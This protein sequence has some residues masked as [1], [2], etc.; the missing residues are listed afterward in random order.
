MTPARPRRRTLFGTSALAVAAL[1]LSACGLVGSPPGGGPAPTAAPTS[2]ASQSAGPTPTAS[3]TR[4]ATPAPTA[5]TT[6]TSTPTATASPP[7]TPAPTAS[8]PPGGSTDAARAWSGTGYADREEW[9]D[10][11][12]FPV[13]IAETWND[14][15]DEN[16]RTTWAKMNALYTV[17]QYFTDANWQGGL[18]LAQPMFAADQNVNTCA[19]EEQ[20]RTVMTNLLNY[21]PSGDAFIR[22]SWEFNGNWYHW[23][24]GP[25]DGPAFKAC[26]I[27]WHDI[28][29]SVSPGFKL[30]WNPNAES[31]NPDL[32]VRDFWPGAQY[33][34]A[35]GPDFYAISDNGSLRDVN[36]LGR[37]GEPLGIAA[38]ADW[39]AD[40]GVPF[41][42]PEWGINDQSWGSTSPEFIEQMRTVFETAAKSPSGLAYES[43]F[44]GGTAYSCKFSIHDATCGYDVHKPAA[45]RYAALWNEPYATS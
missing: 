28:V 22:L 24:M 3:T 33:V 10:W 1:S 30:V 7:G 5:P 12:G 37:H 23:S 11:R 2:T 42:V 36:R 41:A 21:W 13:Q 38:W 27:K 40:Q 25:N 31:S 44:D 32:D 4:P 6:P 19:T 29:K 17:K 9:G 14:A 8:A 34:D 45:D 35:A 26:W 43:Y 16:G 15:K 18:S 39:V 20:I